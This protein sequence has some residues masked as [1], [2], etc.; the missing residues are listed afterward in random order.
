MPHLADPEIGFVATANNQPTSEGAGPFLGAD[1]IDGYR[2]DRIVE[3]LDARHDW[4]LPSVQAL[5]MDQKSIPWRELR[6]IVLAIPAETDQA[7]QAL[8]LLEAW[9]GMVAA[10][11]SAATVF[12]FF[13][14]EMIQRVV[15]A[16]APRA[17]QW[18]LGEGFTSL[19]PHT[20][21]YVRRVGHLVRLL[22][23]QPEGWFERSWPQEMAD[24]LTT[25]VRSL[26]KHY[27]DEPDGWAWGHIRPLTLRHP[28]GERAPFDRVFN[29]GPFP[30]GGDAN[31]VGAASAPP[32][33]PTTNPL[34]I[35]S[36]RMVVDVGNWEENRFAL[37]GGQSGNPLSTHYAD[38]LPLWQRG[39]GVPIAWSPEEVARV[40][41]FT[42]RLVPG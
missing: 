22:Q 35:A 21:F 39:E 2:Q 32:S 23:E 14:A 16:K 10:D 6:D 13:V 20:V 36:L 5:Q 27:G 25:V 42:L 34:T 15:T 18:A 8:A 17:A 29:L 31:T 1:W 33:N 26:R 12:E 7:R 30:W 4:D 11:S 41:Q 3:A 9:D 24:A 28:V 19:I 40:T 38:L 37:P